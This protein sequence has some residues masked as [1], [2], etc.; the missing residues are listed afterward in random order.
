MANTAKPATKRTTLSQCT[1]MGN[2]RHRIGGYWKKSEKKN[3]VQY[4]VLHL[5][6][7]LEDEENSMLIQVRKSEY[8][9]CT[10]PDV[11]VCF[12]NETL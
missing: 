9:K 1:L 5:D 3:T 6:T 4:H 2:Q 12:R 8:S 10:I 11:K 7:T